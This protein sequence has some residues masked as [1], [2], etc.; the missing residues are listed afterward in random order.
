MSVQTPGCT[1]LYS[2]L[3]TFNLNQIIDEPT[4]IT[5]SSSTLLDVIC[6]DRGI[7]VADSGTRDMLDMSDHRMIFANLKLKAPNFFAG[8]ISYRHFSNFDKV[9]FDDDMQQI[10]FKLSEALDLR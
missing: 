10:D 6:A 5:E 7:G 4:R 9:L 1:Y 3:H 2:I 8:E